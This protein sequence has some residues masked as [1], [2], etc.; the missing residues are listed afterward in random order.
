MLTHKKSVCSKYTCKEVPGSLYLE[1]TAGSLLCF[2]PPGQLLTQPHRSHLRMERSP[3][4]ASPQPCCY[5]LRPSIMTSSLDTTIAPVCASIC[6][7]TVLFSRAPRVICEN[8]HHT[9][10]IKPNSPHSGGL[11]WSDEL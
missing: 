10:L 7:T 3:T 5:S 11:V 9:C 1:E 2:A 4:P 6:P 8:P